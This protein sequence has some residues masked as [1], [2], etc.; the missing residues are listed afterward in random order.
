MEI[1]GDSNQD[2]ADKTPEDDEDMMDLEDM[3]YD[4]TRMFK[5]E[6]CYGMDR[7]FSLKLCEN[8]NKDSSKCVFCLC[9]ECY[10]DGGVFKNTCTDCDERLHD[11]KNL[12][13]EDNKNNFKSIITGKSIKRRWR[14]KEDGFVCHYNV[15][16]NA[17]GGL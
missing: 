2:T 17:G 15:V 12:L 9:P 11:L 7:Q 3:S 8:A 1:E 13:T 10:S 4:D 16:G 5:A 14:R 6:D